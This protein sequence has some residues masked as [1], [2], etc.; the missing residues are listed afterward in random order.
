MKTTGRSFIGIFLVAMAILGMFIGLAGIAGAWVANGAL[1]TSLGDT[2][3][4]LDTTL[5]ASADGLALADRLLG[6][7]EISLGGAAG[8]LQA[9]GKSIQEIAPVIDSLAQVAAKDVPNTITKAQQALQSAQASAQIVDTTLSLL[10]SI[11]FL[12]VTRYSPQVPLADSLQEIST[13]LGPISKSLAALEGPIKNSGSNLAVMQARVGE[14]AAAMKEINA[15][16]EEARKLVARYQGV[17][18]TLQPQ[19][20]QARSNLPATID[21]VS[22]LLTLF[23]LWLGLAQI[24]LLIQGL[25]WAGFLGDRVRA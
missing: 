6:Q 21:L 13:S 4:L 10:T 1:K 7:A 15:S 19:L 18:A 2:L 20:G 23:F 16:L 24:G 12:P 8:A 3:A 5:Q 22:V 25:Q 11:P 9:T 14:I 17:V